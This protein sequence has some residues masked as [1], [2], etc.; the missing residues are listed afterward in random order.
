[1]VSKQQASADRAAQANDE[2]VKESCSGDLNTIRRSNRDFE[3]EKITKEERDR[4][5]RTII[6][7]YE[8]GRE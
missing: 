5:H 4:I 2:R 7:D 8:L 1:M 3:Q 6:P